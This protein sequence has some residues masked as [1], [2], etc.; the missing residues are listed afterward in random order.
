MIEIADG[1]WKVKCRLRDCGKQLLPERA[2]RHRVQLTMKCGRLSLLN[3]GAC[4]IQDHHHRHAR[5]FEPDVLFGF[6]PTLNIIV[7]VLQC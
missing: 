1:T 4:R 7:A 2:G 5:C 3:I 6:P